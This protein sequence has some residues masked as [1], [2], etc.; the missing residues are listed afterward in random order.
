[1][2]PELLLEPSRSI[3]DNFL[4]YNKKPKIT[5]DTKETTDETN[6]PENSHWITEE[7]T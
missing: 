7:K 4:W 5:E 1:M 3:L 6:N 2:S